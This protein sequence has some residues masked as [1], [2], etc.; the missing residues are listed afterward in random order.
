MPAIQF[1]LGPADDSG[2]YWVEILPENYFVELSSNL[3]ALCM[4]ESGITTSDGSPYWLLGDNFLRGWYS[5]HDMENERMGFAPLSDSTA[6]AP[7]TSAEMGGTP[8]QDAPVYEFKIATWV[9]IL[10][11]VLIVGILVYFIVD[12]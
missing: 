2:N 9:W 4:F 1:Y 3:C 8:T 10:I 7:M 11:I 6:T 5:I 12:W